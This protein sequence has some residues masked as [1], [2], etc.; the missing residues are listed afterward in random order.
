MYLKNGI[1]RFFLLK[2]LIVFLVIRFSGELI[3]EIL[4]L[5][6]FLKIRGIRS[7]I[8]LIWLL[9]VIF[10]IIGISIV[11]VLLLEI[12]V[13]II[14]LIRKINILRF[15]FVLVYFSKILFDCYVKFVLKNVVLSIYMVMIRIIFV[16]MIEVKIFLVLIILVK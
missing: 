13:D 10:K 4:V 9:V 2:V 7:L 15:F 12:K 14:L 5:I 6:V 8:G 1:D 16:F 11:I 3:I